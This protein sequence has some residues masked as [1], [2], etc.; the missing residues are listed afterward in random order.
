M[1]LIN[2]NHFDMETSPGNGHFLTNNSVWVL[3]FMGEQAS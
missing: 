3:L 1:L 2:Y